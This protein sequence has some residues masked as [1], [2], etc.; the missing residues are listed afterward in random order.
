MCKR[1]GPLNQTNNDLSIKGRRYYFEIFL[2][3]SKKNSELEITKG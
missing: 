2:I 1:K 3:S